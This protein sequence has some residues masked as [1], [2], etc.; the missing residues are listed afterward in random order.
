VL[1]RSTAIYHHTLVEASEIEHSIVLENCKIVD[2]P[3]RIE[4]SLIGRSV[5]ITRSPVKPKAFKLVLG[6]HSK[7][8]IL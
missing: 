3:Q 7:V 5:E 6:D 2:I 8:G 1:F 4:S